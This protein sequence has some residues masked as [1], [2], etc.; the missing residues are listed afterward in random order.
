AG[1][2]G[3]VQPKTMYQMNVFGLHG[4]RV[5]TD[6]EGIDLALRM[7]DLQDELPPGFLAGFPGAPDLKR[8]L[9]RRHLAGESSHDGRRF[10]IAR[11]L[12]DCRPDISCWDHQ[13]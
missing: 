13:Q 7:N 9:L 10:E 2:T 5:R 4:R 12:D 11:G 6:V 3:D 8:L 1:F